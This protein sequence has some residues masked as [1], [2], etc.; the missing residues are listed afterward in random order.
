MKMPLDD[1]VPSAAPTQVKH[2]SFTQHID[3]GIAT[4]EQCESTTWPEERRNAERDGR[5]PPTLWESCGDVIGTK[6]GIVARGLFD[7]QLD[8]WRASFPEKAFCLLSNDVLRANTTSAVRRIAAFAGLD[9]SGAWAEEAEGY[10]PTGNAATHNPAN[11]SSEAAAVE[12]LRGFYK[13]RSKAYTR[14]VDSGGWLN[15]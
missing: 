3:V 6:S 2:G 1:I 10:K 13:S 11:L 14:L 15:C 4:W 12:R 9:P 5:T 7:E 8:N